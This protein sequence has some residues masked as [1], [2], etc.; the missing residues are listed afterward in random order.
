V[1]GGRTRMEGALVLIVL[2]RRTAECCFG[3][4]AVISPVEES[5]DGHGLGPLGDGD[6][7]A[8]EDG[9]PLT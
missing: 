6:D 4:E 1:L 8:E 9:E 2:E 3:E 5:V 7:A